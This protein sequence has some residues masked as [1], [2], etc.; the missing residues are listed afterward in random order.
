MA[1]KTISIDIEAY[2]RLKKLKKANESF[3]QTIKRVL[4]Q[5][6]DWDAWAK[7][8]GAVDLSRPTTHA[9]E[10]HVATRRNRTRRQR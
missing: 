4:P 7:K 8:M 1:V 3:S 10:E 5:P 2:D 6:F 9:I